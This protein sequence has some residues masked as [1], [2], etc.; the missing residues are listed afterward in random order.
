MVY[1]YSIF[2]HTVGEDFQ[3][4]LTPCDFFFFKWVGLTKN[5]QLLYID[6]GFILPR[7]WGCFFSSKFCFRSSQHRSWSPKL[8]SPLSGDPRGV[9][10]GITGWLE[11]VPGIWLAA[12]LW[13]KGTYCWWKKSCTTNDDDYPIVYRVLTIPGG[14]GFCPSTVLKNKQHLLIRPHQHLLYSHY[15]HSFFHWNRNFNTCIYLGTCWKI[16]MQNIKIP[17][18]HPGSPCS[19]QWD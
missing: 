9:T 8:Q 12:W 5:H 10:W 19:Q 14:A 2:T 1:F 13:F 17:D 15:A 18:K 7:G 3:P 16:Q 11:W 6:W 4:N